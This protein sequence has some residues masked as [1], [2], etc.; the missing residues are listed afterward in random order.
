MP[1]RYEELG[2]L[3]RGH[4]G[5]VAAV[6]FSYR[7]TYI[8][9]AGVQDCTV[10]VWRVADQKLLHTYTSSSAIL[11]LA[12]Y[13]ESEDTFLC[14]THGGSIASISLRPHDLNLG[15]FWAHRFPIEHLKVRGKW[16]ASGATQE[17]AIWQLKHDTWVH[18]VDLP[19]PPH[20]SLNDNREVLVTGI[21][22]TK[23]GTHPSLL[24]VTFMFHG[25]SIFDGN[26]WS[27][28]RHIPLQGPIA[29]ASISPDGTTIAISNMVS[30]FDLYDLTSQAALR[31][32]TH[33]VTTLRAVPVLF[34]HGGH[35]LLG[36]ST[37]GKVHLWDVHNGLLHQ[38]LPLGC[39]LRYGPVAQTPMTS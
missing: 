17:V 23:S 9:T 1:L 32:F 24:L 22:W 4:T 7:G 20:S 29:Y 21:H 26:T 37:V 10:Y 12:W 25:I 31:S 38:T 15:G 11:S 16:L 30:G 28:V 8:V 27:A 2:R 33:P 39:K 34:V 6:A 18:V 5:G 13:A 3:T 36:G 35:A 19:E 14:G